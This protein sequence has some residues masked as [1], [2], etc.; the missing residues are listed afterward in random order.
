MTLYPVG[1]NALTEVKLSSKWKG[2][3]R[4]LQLSWAPAEITASW[5]REQ[6]SGNRAT[7]TAAALGQA[8]EAWHLEAFEIYN[9]Q[10]QRFKSTIRNK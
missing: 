2:Q 9:C 1:K 3:L 6:V 4:A 5:G 10:G 8:R 7:I